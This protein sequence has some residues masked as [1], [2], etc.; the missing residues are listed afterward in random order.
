M[1]KMWLKNLKQ[2]VVVSGLLHWLFL[3]T[4]ADI[5]KRYDSCTLLN[6]IDKKGSQGRIG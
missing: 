4:Y 2:L 5:K 3:N 6:L 1:A